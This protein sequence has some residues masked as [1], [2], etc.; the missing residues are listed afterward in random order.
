MNTI[1]ESSLF[2]LAAFLLVSVTPVKVSKQQLFNETSWRT[3]NFKCRDAQPRTVYASEILGDKF[4]TDKVYVP[5]MTVLHKC[6]NSG[7]CQPNYFCN[8]ETIED[9]QLV[10]RAEKDKAHGKKERTY[11][12]VIARN[13]TSCHCSGIGNI[14]K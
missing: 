9:I 2:I 12:S 7:C 8:A 14:P 5:H 6:Y 1:M 10:F 13:H 4:E 3:N 11:V